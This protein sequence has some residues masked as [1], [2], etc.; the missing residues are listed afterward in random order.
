MAL[1]RQG[2]AKRTSGDIYRQLL[3]F[4][5]Q[6]HADAAN[7]KALTDRMWGQL[8]PELRAYAE[9]S[10]ALQ[11]HYPPQIH[12]NRLAAIYFETYPDALEARRAFVLD[13]NE[14]LRTHSDR[15]IGAQVWSEMYRML[16]YPLIHDGQQFVTEEQVWNQI[17]G[18]LE[19]EL[20]H[21][22]LIQQD[23]VFRDDREHYAS[24]RMPRLIRLLKMVNLPSADAE[25]LLKSELELLQSG[26]LDDMPPAI[27]DHCYRESIRALTRLWPMVKE[28]DDPAIA[29]MIIHLMG[30]LN[31]H[32]WTLTFGARGAKTIIAALRG[33]YGLPSR[34]ERDIVELAVARLVP[35][36]RCAREL[37]VASDQCPDM[38]RRAL[39]TKVIATF[40]DIRQ[41][42]YL[43]GRATAD[44]GLIEALRETGVVT[45][46]E[47]QE[48]TRRY[49]IPG[50]V[51]PEPP[52][53]GEDNT[54]WWT[55]QLTITRNRHIYTQTW[56]AENVLRAECRL[57]SLFW[58]YQPTDLTMYNQIAAFFAE[59]RH[60]RDGYR[61]EVTVAYSRDTHT[62]RAKLGETLDITSLHIKHLQRIV[63]DYWLGT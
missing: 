53:S 43:E 48:L 18:E 8:S 40:S 25:R 37:I 28:C 59:A 60:D 16:H 35:A 41:N 61:G 44:T 39:M 20:D 22:W 4:F 17:E 10:W 23:A 5:A 62:A 34:V 6:S 29:K 47:L 9:F 38:V 11:P 30:R 51:Q 55:R 45:V 57:I 56:P 52:P 36:M 2:H 58:Q 54:E 21:L 49:G 19:G 31:M 27:R 33:G 24:E 63:G 42:V 7:Y 32:P 50:D 26:V 1:V 46:T 12:A 13:W 15:Q 14:A 3:I